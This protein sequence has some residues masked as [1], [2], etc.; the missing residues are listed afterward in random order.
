MAEF[1]SS[2]MGALR[3]RKSRW[4]VKL[5][6]GLAVFLLAGGIVWWYMGSQ[7][8]RPDPELLDAKSQ[9]SFTLYY[10]RGLDKISYSKGSM[11]AKKD[12]VIFSMTYDG[13]KKLYISQQPKPKNVVFDDFYK[14]VLNNKV[15]VFSS[16]GKAVMGAAGGQTLGSLVTDKVWVM[17]NTKE[18]IDG[19]LMQQLISSLAPL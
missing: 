2:R 18:A 4:G 13:G 9:A 7:A 10:P 14:R 8:S 6:V 19:Q 3:V 12:L 5:A 16:Q 17:A 11:K 1:E 15:D